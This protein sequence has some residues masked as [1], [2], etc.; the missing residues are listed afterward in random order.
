ML[1]ASHLL[2]SILATV[3]S[4]SAALRPCLLSRAGFAVVTSAV[5]TQETDLTACKWHLMGW[6][7]LAKAIFGFESFSE[8]GVYV[9]ASAEKRG[10]SYPSEHTRV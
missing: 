8:F 2:I 1:D 9:L 4:D 10:G 5:W 7:Y 6:D 3:Q